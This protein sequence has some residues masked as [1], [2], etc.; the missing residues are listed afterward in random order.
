MQVY[1]NYPNAH[2]TIHED[3]SCPLV[4]MHEKEQQRRVK[5]RPDNR[6]VALSEFEHQH[7]EFRAEKALNDLWLDVALG[8]REAEIGLVREIQRIL[9]R[10][11]SRLASAM[12]NVHCT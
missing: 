1:M 2:I 5:I 4:R 8:S 9:G 10:R 12:V 6:E 11:Y 7:Y 3:E